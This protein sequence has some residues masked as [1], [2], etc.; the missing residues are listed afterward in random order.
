MFTMPGPQ[1][2]ILFVAICVAVYVFV[3]V[4]IGMGE[5][6]FP[7]ER[8]IRDPYL[9]AYLRG[10]T[11][12]VIRVAT[13]ALLLRGLLKATDFKL[14][15]VDS[16]EIDRAGVPIEKALLTACRDGA[17]PAQ[18]L[19]NSGIRT[20]ANQYHNRLIDAG[21]IPSATAESLRR[22]AVLIG[23]AV[24]VTVAAAKIVVAL[25][26]GHSNILFLVILAVL[27]AVLLFAKLNQRLTRRGRATLSEL[28]TL[29]ASVKSR[30]HTLPASAIPEATL[31]AAVFGVYLPFGMAQ[32]VWEKMFPPPSTS[33]SSGYDSSSS[34]S[35][36][37]S[38]SSGGCGGGGGGGGCG[39]CGS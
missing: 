20:A 5:A 30:V 8:R 4:A 28:R 1:F 17:I 29:F 10:D 22:R 9:I 19:G 32:G 34:S 33:A 36:G 7:A 13:L 24:V 2:L 27:A 14:S 3:T 12:E 39:G 11:D 21:L 37:S 35:C 23:I 16:S 18:I 6:G 26:T 25:S 31:L 38:D 15:T